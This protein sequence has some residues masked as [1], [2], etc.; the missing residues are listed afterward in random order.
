MSHVPDG[1]SLTLRQCGSAT[2]EG[3]ASP[4]QADHTPPVER[5]Y[6][7]EIQNRFRGP[8]RL[9]AGSPGGTKSRT[10]E[11]TSGRRG[12]LRGDEESLKSEKK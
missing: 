10:G 12:V 7:R 1:V 5:R 11:R 8:E 2:R 4:D 3:A 6:S 9:R